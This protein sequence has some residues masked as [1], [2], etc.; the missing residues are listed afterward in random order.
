MNDIRVR[1]DIHCNRCGNLGYV[2]ATDGLGGK[3][4]YVCDCPHGLFYGENEKKDKARYG[5]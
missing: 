2:Q 5:E 4:K 1:P 3:Y